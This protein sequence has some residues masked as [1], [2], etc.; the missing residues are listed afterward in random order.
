MYWCF[1]QRMNFLGHFCQCKRMEIFSY[2]TMLRGR[3]FIGTLLIMKENG[4][5]GYHMYHWQLLQRMNSSTCKCQNRIFIVSL[6]RYAEN[7]PN[8]KYFNSISGS[9]AY[10][11][12]GMLDQKTGIAIDSDSMSRYPC[13]HIKSLFNKFGNDI[14]QISNMVF[15][16]TKKVWEFEVFEDFPANI[17]VDIWNDGVHLFG[18]IDNDG[19]LDRL[20]PTAQDSN[21]LRL[22]VPPTGYSGW[23]LNIDD[24]SLKWTVK[25][26]GSDL[27]NMLNIIL[28]S[29][30]PIFTG[31]LA[32]VFYKFAFYFIYVNRE[33]RFQSSQKSPK[34]P[35]VPITNGLADI[36]SNSNPH[37]T[38]LVATLEY[39]IPEWKIKVRI[40]GLGVIAS[41]M[42]VNLQGR[43]VWV[44]PMVG[45]IEYPVP[46]NMMQI[47]ILI[48]QQLVIINAFVFS[49]RNVT[50]YLL[51]SPIFRKQ[52]SL[53][54]YP[55]RMNNVE[56]ACFYSCWNQCIAHILEIEPIDIY[57]VNDFHG[58]LAPFYVHPVGSIRCVLS[59]HNA[60][61]QGLWPVRTEQEERS[62]CSIFNLP[63]T[64]CNE[65]IRFGHVF[66]L[67]HGIANYIS[68]YQQG[69][70]CGGVSAA[71]GARCQ[72]RFPA[73][74]SLKEMESV[75]NPNPADVVMREDSIVNLVNS[76]EDCQTWAGLNLDQNA[77]LLMFLGRFSHQKGIDVIADLAGKILSTYQNVQLLCIGPI[78]DLHGRLSAIKLDH[79]AKIYPGRLVCK[80]EFTVIPM[81][82]FE[83]TDFVLIP[84]RDEPFGLVAVEFGQHGV[85]GIGSLV[86]G[87]GTMPG[88]WYP[89]ESPDADHIKRQ[90]W[91]TIKLA[92]KSSESQ[93]K[94]MRS[95]AI[96]QRF[97]VAEWL[98]KLD[99]LYQKVLQASKGPV[100]L[101]E[102]K[103]IPLTN[104]TEV[105][106]PPTTSNWKNIES[107]IDDPND[108][109]EQYDDIDGE[110]QALVIRNLTERKHELI[111]SMILVQKRK[112]YKQI[113][114]DRQ[115][116]VC[117]QTTNGFSN[118]CQKICNT[119]ILNWP[120]YGIILCIGQLMGLASF[121]ITIISKASSFDSLDFYLLG[122]A[123]IIGCI[124][125]YAL[126][127]KKASKLGLCGPFVLYSLAFIG[128][129]FPY[130]SRYYLLPIQMIYSF[131][132]AS[133]PLFFALNFG[134]EDGSEIKVWIYR[135]ILGESLRQCYVLF[136]SNWSRMYVST[137]IATL[138]TTIICVPF[139]ALLGM[140]FILLYA[141][142][143]KFYSFTPPSIPNF[144]RTLFRRNMVLWYWLSEFVKGY[145]LN[146]V[147]GRNL[148]Y[149]WSRQIPVWSS[150]VIIIAL[151]ALGATLMTMIAIA[152]KRHTWLLPV[153]SV[154]LLSPRWAQISFSL[155]AT[156]LSL[157]W[158]RVYSEYIAASVWMWLGVLDSIQA[159]G[160]SI[161][162]LQ[163][164]INM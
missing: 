145:W 128:L 2:T 65:F 123:F 110:L 139:S 135:S 62:L 68:K 147:Y 109:W 156:G 99:A 48:C 121:Q 5:A 89:M 84:S 51:E 122:I 107:V 158:G 33:G 74:W 104:K 161:M 150:V 108:V 54:P 162:L 43:L 40:G 125:W 6:Y 149:F 138:T 76:K 90:L 151:G 53:N 87:L 72:L 69:I 9:S 136:L 25:P 98:V 3:I 15:S 45:D 36:E 124:F 94:A 92:L 55:A 119:E 120:I 82:V 44:V 7:Q 28:I 24:K 34:T 116:T 143:P 63:P 18:D 46:E 133:G 100:K 130:R 8:K 22:T 103:L 56:S 57:H 47:P 75:E 23:L 132:S 21:A 58:G 83:A 19:V 96:K 42:G 64:T 59:L 126:Y 97:P 137:P 67:L 77:T 105:E 37:P 153:F 29:A 10:K 157:Y 70:G 41:L 35:V 20:P 12:H 11:S 131:A 112:F 154:G 49:T 95:V 88:W 144:I 146:G 32:V 117:G 26:I 118:T 163:V 4:L 111:D 50:Y 113:D 13:L 127:F 152:S 114:F 81:F 60:E 61:F 52:T 85:L 86:G 102:L 148:E 164:M 39:D 115:Q 134:A 155:S 27:K 91:V 140:Y 160:I 101:R 79:I 1:L 80:A 141:G 71:Y 78:I 106:L 159:V 142:L 38:I 66:N 31:I 73:L 30:I 16:R 14:T 129:A 93:R 17:T